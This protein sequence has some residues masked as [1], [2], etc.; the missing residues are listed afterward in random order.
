MAGRNT[1]V[2]ASR[3]VRLMLLINGNLDAMIEKKN[4]CN[5]NHFVATCRL[6][7]CVT[8]RLVAFCH[9]VFLLDW[10]IR[11][12]SIIIGCGRCKYFFHPL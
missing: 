2:T 6:M 8:E 1:V 9:D 7:P 3:Y 10:W 4:W 5:V 12:Q 11:V